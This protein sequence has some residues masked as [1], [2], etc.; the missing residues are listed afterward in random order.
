[1][2]SSK[3]TEKK[4]LVLGGTGKTGSRVVTRLSQLGYPVRIGSR[5]AEI[6]FD[7]DNPAT[8]KPALADI[9][10]V[11]ITFQ[12][13]LAVPLAPGCIES[14]S[15][16]AVE[17]GVEKLVLLSGRGEEEA[18]RC[19]KIVMNAG[20]EWTIVRASW[21]FQNFSESYFLEDLLA[22]QVNL[23]V[24]AIG[25]PFVDADDI[26]DVAIAALTQEGHHGQVY[27]VTGSRLLTFKQAIEEIN[28]AAG[29]AIQYQQVSAD[30]YV[31]SLVSSQIPEEYVSLLT[32]LF[33]QVMDGRNSYTVNGIEKAIGRKPT[34]F[35][36]YARKTAATGIWNS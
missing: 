2:Q 35:S 6:P 18:Q 24:G 10:A 25:E 8:W 28:T 22:G 20:A 34:D 11:Y 33:T 17:N 31:A 19:E 30:E 26:A 32:Y 4:I 16:L 36:E 29:K 12:P 21:F 23:P 14:F 13:D 3:N 1:M 15:R 7:W 5:T 9:T 27:E